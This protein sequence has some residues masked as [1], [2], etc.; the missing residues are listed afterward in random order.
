M[1]IERKVQNET[2]RNPYRTGANVLLLVAFFLLFH[3]L[4]S[5][6]SLMYQPTISHW[7]TA[8]AFVPLVL[9]PWRRNHPFAENHTRLYAAVLLVQQAV[10]RVETIS[11][12]SRCENHSGLPASK[13]LNWQNKKRL[14]LAAFSWP[15]RC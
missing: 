6:G 11:L 13:R 4:L 5:R 2:G 14:L 15:E 10:T 7:L 1:S 3:P 8:C 9:R 12:K